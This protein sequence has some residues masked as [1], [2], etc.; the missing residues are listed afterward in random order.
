M[1][2]QTIKI[3]II[4]TGIFAHRHNRAYQAVGGKKFEIVACANRSKDKALA[5]AK[6]VGIPES[7]VYTSPLDLINDPNVDA[8]DI[9]LPVQFN[10][11]IIQAAVAANKH[12]MFEKPIAANLKDARE[13]VK[14]AQKAKT[15]V[16]VNENWAY[17]P[18]AYA[19]AEYVKNGGIGE[20]VNFTYDSSR[21]YS[22]NS[23]YHNT[24][25][26]QNPEHPGGYLSDG[27]VHD[28]AHL[29]PILGNIEKVGAFATKRHTIHVCE[30][31]LATTVKLANGAVGTANFTFVSKKN[32]TLF[33]SY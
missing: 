3:G 1:S 10:L 28:M 7:A 18:L 15:V 32:H 2:E 13:I 11:E 4:G 14:V 8:V 21:P 26:R 30:D 25:W 23:P 20:L 22:P 6:E 17:H 19:V 16:A 12:V 31:T 33:S 27:C 24:K 9:L 5:F 29:I